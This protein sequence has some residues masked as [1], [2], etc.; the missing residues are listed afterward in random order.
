MIAF[1]DIKGKEGPR[2]T[3]ELYMF[4][5]GRLLSSVSHTGKPS[6]LKDMP[7]AQT[8]VF[9][10]I[11]MGMLDMRVV[12]L[13]FSDIE[14]VKE[15]LPFEL[16]GI[17]LDGPEGVVLDAAP[18]SGGKGKKFLAVYAKKDFIR[19]LLDDF[20]GAGIDPKAVT[21]IEIK[22]AIGA[23]TEQA[24]INPEPIPDE[25]RISLAE[26]ELKQGTIN[27]RRG[28]FSYTKDAEKTRKSARTTAVIVALIAVFFFADIS[29][30]IASVRRESSQI[31]N[32]L[33][34]GYSDLFPG[35]RPKTHKELI[36]RLKSRMKE[37]KGKKEA[38]VGASP[39][40]AMLKLSASELKVAAFSE[41][42]IDRERILLK[43]EAPSLGDVEGIK[44]ALNEFFSD[45]NI[46]DAK[47][48]ASEK[49][50]FTISMR[51]KTD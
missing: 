35:E 40:N 16:E 22:N 41:M 39:L 24:L 31:K 14:R 21:S 12:E 29:L 20:K 48:S 7:S 36:L 2:Y 27:L 37:I 45:V 34:K 10:S 50:L 1:F 13:P 49:T 32:E 38:M 9:L 18:L 3:F 26:K 8:E 17:I 5:K 25:R 28:E 43:G 46:T 15:V 33:M 4:E 51:E 6:D 44:K 47:K 11:P 30:R 42:I 19:K 23:E